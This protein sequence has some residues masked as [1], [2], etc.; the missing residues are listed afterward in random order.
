MKAC[1]SLPGVFAPMLVKERREEARIRTAMR[2]TITYATD[3]EMLFDFAHHFS[4]ILLQL[5]EAK[6]SRNIEEQINQMTKAKFSLKEELRAIAAEGIS[7][8]P[9]QDEVLPGLSLSNMGR[10]EE[11]IEHA[12][13]ASSHLFVGYQRIER[14][15]SE[16]RLRITALEIAA[17]TNELLRNNMPPN[18]RCNIKDLNGAVGQLSARVFG[19]LFVDQACEFVESRIASI[20]KS[21]TLLAL[22]IVFSTEDRKFDKI[23]PIK[24]SAVV[25]Q[26]AEKIAYEAV[27]SIKHTVMIV[28]GGY[29]AESAENMEKRACFMHGNDTN[30][31]TPGSMAQAFDRYDKNRRMEALSRKHRASSEERVA[32]SVSEPTE[33]EYNRARFI[34]NRMFTNYRE[35]FGQDYLPDLLLGGVE[36]QMKD[37][38]VYD[39]LVNLM[40]GDVTTSAKDLSTLY[41]KQDSSKP[42]LATQLENI[43]GKGKMLESIIDTMREVTAMLDQKEE[44][45]SQKNIGGK[46]KKRQN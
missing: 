5:F 11:V 6:L 2:N 23:S 42:S 9:I 32:C 18:Y 40:L 7:P 36:E 4:K 41:L 17:P 20:M 46:N 29:R 35:K 39:Y 37:G 33:E 45:K 26:L 1:K 28:F 24:M 31:P 25:P 44:F 19:C 8:F 43:V 14:L 3:R 34:F 27:K 15:A 22:E 13:E 30:N 16:M 21:L 38:V 12:E 10:D